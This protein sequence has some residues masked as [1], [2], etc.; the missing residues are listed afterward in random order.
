MSQSPARER[1]PSWPAGM[2]FALR[3]GKQEREASASGRPPFGCLGDQP[4]I[5]AKLGSAC[6]LVGR[7]VSGLVGGRVGRLVSGFVG[8]LGRA[9]GRGRRLG[10]R[11]GRLARA[12]QRE[13]P[14]AQNHQQCCELLHRGHLSSSGW[15]VHRRGGN[16]SRPVPVK[17][18]PHPW[19][20]IPNRVKWPSHV[21][22]VPLAGTA[23]E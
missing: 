3:M 8:R 7:R 15:E 21:C 11:L 23:V 19:E 16:H 4:P 20:I 9:C 12:A 18:D 1:L 22:R 2:H 6:R 14:E 10:C 17:K 5:V 13:Q